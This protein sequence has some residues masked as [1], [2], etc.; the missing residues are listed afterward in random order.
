MRDIQLDENYDLK[1]TNGDFV[2]G[3]S[4]QQNVE[5]ILKINPGELKEHLQTGVGI[6]RAIN[7]NN[8]RFLDRLIRVQMETDNFN[9]EKLS[10]K[11]N[12]IAIQGDYGQL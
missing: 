11:K 8:D 2:I 3:D 9:I 7:S 12:G 10:I 1:I 6:D 5:L 4:S